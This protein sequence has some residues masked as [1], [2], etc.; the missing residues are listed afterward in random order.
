VYQFSSGVGL[1]LANWV[2]GK[3]AG[4]MTGGALGR[5]ID[6]DIPTRKASILTMAG[7]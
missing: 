7:D 2:G 3:P 6:R 5:K 4:K 1:I